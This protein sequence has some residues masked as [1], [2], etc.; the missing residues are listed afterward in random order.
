MNRTLFFINCVL[1]VCL[2]IANFHEP[3]RPAYQND[4]STSLSKQMSGT[5][6]GLQAAQ[7][8]PGIQVNSLPAPFNLNGTMPYQVWVNGK[9]LPLNGEKADQIVEV[10]DLGEFVQPEDTAEIHQ[11]VGWIT[12]FPIQ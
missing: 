1:V 3:T 5:P 10:L 8:S 6:G 2:S 12:P 9:R 7:A 4:K 11:G